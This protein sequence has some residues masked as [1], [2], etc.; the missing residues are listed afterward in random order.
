[1]VS[2]IAQHTSAPIRAKAVV[3]EDQEAYSDEGEI[4]PLPSL[5]ASTVDMADRLESGPLQP[6]KVVGQLVVGL[7]AL[8]AIL[9]W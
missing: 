9:V 6:L 5:A 8:G 7:M 4:S 3:G 1:M 2:V